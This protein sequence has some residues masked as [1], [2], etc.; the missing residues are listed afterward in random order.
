ML[1]NLEDFTRI[2]EDGFAYQLPVDV[3]NIIEDLAKEVGT[4]GYVCTPSFAKKHIV[5]RAPQQKE[6]NPIDEI[7]KNMNKLSERTFESLKDKIIDDLE[8]TDP[9]SVAELMFTIASGNAFYSNLYARLY[10]IIC[11]RFNVIDPPKTPDFVFF[12]PI[13]HCNPNDD[14]DRYCEITKTNE[15]RRALALFCVNLMNE[16]AVDSTIVYDLLE[17]IR[18]RIDSSVATTNGKPITDELSELLYIVI[19]NSKERLRNDNRWREYV[20]YIE[21]MTSL[22]Q[23]PENGLTNKCIFKCM[24]LLDAIR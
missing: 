6:K 24:D 22:K 19:V 17:D 20:R 14:Y 1:Y 23:T 21:K 16:G 18:K 7:R 10:K 8:N 5:F 11:D 2:F 12:S 13:E 9:A 4:P 3:R 15:R